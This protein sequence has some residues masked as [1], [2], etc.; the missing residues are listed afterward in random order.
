MYACTLMLG[1]AAGETTDLRHRHFAGFRPG[2]PL[3]PGWRNFKSKFSKLE[4]VGGFK[5]RLSAPAASLL[6]PQVLRCLQLLRCVI[7]VLM[8]QL[9]NYRDSQA[10]FNTTLQPS[11]SL[12]VK[13]W[14]LAI[15]TE[16]TA[17]IIVMLALRIYSIVKL[18]AATERTFSLMKWVSAPRRA[19]QTV[20]TIKRLTQVRTALG[21]LI[22]KP[23]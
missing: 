15:R 23:K 9:V 1:S 16:F 13:R 4:R 17:T 21:A 19:S 12:S 6:R 20:G 2:P 18:A 7:R 3:S 8:E 14:W 22:P 5:L 10:P 11:D